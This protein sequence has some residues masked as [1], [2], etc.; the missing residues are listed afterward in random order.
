MFENCT[1][2]TTAPT[3]PAT[4]LSNSC[5]SNMFSGCT[6]L[7]SAPTL[8][9]TYIYGYSYC[10]MFANCTALTAMPVL[11]ITNIDDNC[12]SGMFYGC[13]SLTSATI[14]D[15]DVNAYDGVTYSEAFRDMFNGCENLN[16]ITCL[17]QD[18][19]SDPAE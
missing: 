13:T 4:T 17:I 15:I 1:S 10:N 5:Y 11:N 12:C 3:L 19:T 9:A 14:P 8:P 6:S 7:T 2:L 16:N 18:F